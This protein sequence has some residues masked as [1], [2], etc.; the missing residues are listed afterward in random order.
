[1]N[2]EI[3][4]NPGQLA[5]MVGAAEAAKPTAPIETPKVLMGNDKGL[6]VSEGLQPEAVEAVPDSAMNRDDPLGKLI[7]AA[8]NLP[9][10]AI[11]VELT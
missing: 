6:T 2:I 1:M 4:N 8:F 10:P 5:Q 3:H 11:P 9:A 7:N